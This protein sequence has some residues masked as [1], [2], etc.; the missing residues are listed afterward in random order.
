[1]AEHI[2]DGF[3]LEDEA[4]EAHDHELEEFDEA[5]AEHEPPVHD[6][7]GVPQ[8][9]TPQGYR[10][11]NPL[12]GV[13]SI[14]IVLAIVGAVL[15]SLLAHPRASLAASPLVAVTP[16]ATTPPDASMPDPTE[17]PL[18]RARTKPVF[19]IAQPAMTPVPATVSAD[20][21]TTASMTTSAVAPQQ[22]I[23]EAAPA[24]DASVPR[25]KTAAEIA[26]DSDGRDL[27]AASRASSRMQLESQDAQAQRDLGG[28]SIASGSSAGGSVPYP[29]QGAPD[30]STAATE[31]DDSFA[32]EAGASG[33]AG[34][35]TAGRPAHSSFVAA[36]SGDPGYE[37]A[38][39]RY[40]LAKGTIIPVRLITAVDSTVPGGLMKAQVLE[41]IFDS[42][43]HSV[44][45]LP[46]GTIA[47][48]ESDSAQFG[49]ARLVT[50]W[51]E[52]DLPNGRR[53]FASSNEGAGS[54]GEA[55][56]SVSVDT[57]AGRAFGNALVGAVLQAGVN[58]A[59]RATSIV[60]VN[61]ATTS[62]QA[63]T[64]PSPTLHAYPGQLFNIVLNHDEPFDRY[65]AASAP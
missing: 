60:D 52:F 21:T 37:S 36:R 49:E 11:V 30:A 13:G 61:S 33:H 32:S 27:A 42:Q 45:V 25:A 46:A 18:G 50:A 58:L 29:V 23:A 55:G 4:S 2:D 41:T 40:E 51:T 38:T 20:T 5:D 62:L 8:S 6:P 48:G 15:W 53:F 39:S 56:M 1:M 31:A 7:G 57:H 63:P 59:S 24:S 65:V 26:A 10:S 47:I 19:S 3:D 9:L 44:A 28:S 14:A 22:Q 17:T 43:T 34:G 54:K 12:L 35:S 64:R 16:G